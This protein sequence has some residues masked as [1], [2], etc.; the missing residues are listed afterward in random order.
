MKIIDDKVFFYT[1]YF[2]NFH[3]CKFIDPSTGLVFPTTEH[4][5]MWFKARFFD[6]HTSMSRLE[7]MFD[8]HPQ[9]AKQV[10]RA[11]ANYDD[12]R[13]ECVRFGYMV[14]ANYLKYSQNQEL[15][16]KLLATGDKIL[17]EASPIDLIWG[18]GLAENEPNEVLADVSKWRGRNLLGKA[19][20]RVR[21]LVTA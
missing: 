12:V 17:V 14:Y 5:F 7:L 9:A 15:K 6:D 8:D 19:L 2:S 21:D 4:A 11:V 16:D 3:R 13:W 20:M 1:N 18:I 10:G